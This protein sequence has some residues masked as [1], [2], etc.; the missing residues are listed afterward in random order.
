MFQGMHRT[1]KP[2]PSDLRSQVLQPHEFRRILSTEWGY[3]GDQALTDMQILEPKEFESFL[4]NEKYVAPSRAV[5]FDRSI[6]IP[7]PGP[8]EGTFFDHLFDFDQNL[9]IKALN[10]DSDTTDYIIPTQSVVTDS[11]PLK[12]KKAESTFEADLLQ[13]FSLSPQAQ[14]PVAQAPVATQ[15]EQAEMETRSFLDVSVPKR[16]HN[17]LVNLRDLDFLLDDSDL[18]A[19]SETA[20]QKESPSGSPKR[21]LRRRREE[22]TTVK[23]NPLVFLETSLEPRALQADQLGNRRVE[24][25]I[26]PIQA[27]AERWGYKGKVRPYTKDERAEVVRRYREKRSKRNFKKR[28]RYRC[29]RNFAVNRPRIGGRFV[30]IKK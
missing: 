22:I 15:R 8:K 24:K 4:S 11:P 5:S 19:R 27:D 3:G 21:E 18:S 12:P 7:Q 2:Y 9:G 13:G 30:K 23:Q 29:R 16:G 26:D 6:T 1:E 25:N 17:A 20:S 10:G 28:V 14:A